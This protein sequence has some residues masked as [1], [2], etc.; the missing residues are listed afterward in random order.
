MCVN[1]TR[2]C[3][4]KNHHEEDRSPIRSRSATQTHL[5]QQQSIWSSFPARTG[6]IRSGSGFLLL[7]VGTE[8]REWVLRCGREL[9]KAVDR[10]L[11]HYSP[12]TF[13]AKNKEGQLIALVIILETKGEPGVQPDSS[14]GASHQSIH[15]VSLDYS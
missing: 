3:R 14:A 1:Q 10:S 9:E 7:R 13:H 11:S 2:G 15:A 6:F 8:C 12:D 4:S 5:S